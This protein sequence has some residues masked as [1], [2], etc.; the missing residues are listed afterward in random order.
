MKRFRVT[1]ARA[2]CEHLAHTGV[3]E[4][5]YTGAMSQQTFADLRLQALRASQDARAFVV[6]VDA[7]DIALTG[8]VNVCATAY[9]DAAPG[10]LVVRQDEYARWLG[11]AQQCAQIGVVRTVWPVAFAKLAYQWALIRAGSV[12]QE[13]PRSLLTRRVFLPAY[14]ESDRAAT[15]GSSP[16]G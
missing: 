11:Y 5:R 9:K 4:A 6:W 15:P 14:R 2:T 10:A 1:R 12:P 8:E 3:V 13:S 16:Q 7:A